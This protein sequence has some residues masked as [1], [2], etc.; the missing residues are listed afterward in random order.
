MY[1][2]KK[3]CCWQVVSSRIFVVQELNDELFACTKTTGCALKNWISG[4]IMKHV[5]VQT[6]TEPVHMHIITVCMSFLCYFLCSF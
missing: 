2:W 3:N 5:N 4:C 6:E 1:V